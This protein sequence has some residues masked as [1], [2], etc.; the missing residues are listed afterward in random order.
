FL[1]KNIHFYGLILF[2][3]GLKVVEV[4][5]EFDFQK[6][7]N[8]FLFLL[9][10]VVFQLENRVLVELFLSYQKTFRF[11]TYKPN[12]FHIQKRLL[13]QNSASTVDF[14]KSFYLLHNQ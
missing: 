9:T 4:F 7:A 2:S 5:V 1:S 8:D 13:L 14:Y 3:P 11:L 12:K 10:Y 6:M